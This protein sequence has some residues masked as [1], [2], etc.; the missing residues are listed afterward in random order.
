MSKIGRDIISYLENIA[1]YPL[2]KEGIIAGQC[3]A[4]TYF[5][6]LNIPIVTRIKDIDIFTAS[7]HNKNTEYNKENKSINYNISYIDKK[8]KFNQIKREDSNNTYGDEFSNI[9]NDSFNFKESLYTHIKQYKI[10]YV[11]ELENL[12]IVNIKESTKNNRNFVKTIVESFDINMVKIGVCLKTGY[13]Y[14]SEDFKTFLKKKQ[15]EIVDFKNPFK[16]LTRYLNK[17]NT[18]TGFYSD[19]NYVASLIYPLFIFKKA[20]LKSVS[21]DSFNNLTEKSKKEI[22]KYFKLSTK[23]HTIVKRLIIPLS[24]KYKNKITYKKISN[25]NYKL[26]KAMNENQ[27]IYLQ[28]P[29]FDYL[30]SYNPYS[31]KDIIE[32]IKKHYEID[33]VKDYI[34]NSQKKEI[35]Q[36]IKKIRIKYNPKWNKNKIVI[37]TVKEFETVYYEPKIRAFNKTVRDNLESLIKI[38]KMKEFLED[39]SLL[40]NREFLEIFFNNKKINSFIN[41]LYTKEKDTKYKSKIDVMNNLLLN[42]NNKL[43]QIFQLKKEYFLSFIRHNKL[44]EIINLMYIFKNTPFPLKE[45]GEKIIYLENFDIE[46][47]ALFE[48][49]ILPSSLFLEEMDK[50]K[51]E[52]LDINNKKMKNIEKLKQ[53]DFLK[54]DEKLLEFKNYKIIQIY[55]PYRLKEVGKEMNHCVGGYSSKL[56]NKKMLFF[57]VYNPNK[58]RRTLSVYLEKNI[59]ME[60]KNS[61]NIIIDKFYGIDLS[62]DQYKGKRNLYP[63]NNE[64]NEIIEFINILHNR[65][66]ENIYKKDSYLLEE[67]GIN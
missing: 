37:W 7:N 38:E 47:I 46:F 8:I 28:T 36:V 65:L 41:F 53:K 11:F 58:E 43:N 12:N 14:I 42:K 39:K 22:N 15:L 51:K 66:N 17:I 54:L 34:N 63:N 16:T 26:N 6:L 4:E 61:K 48:T 56:S 13:L 55:N 50:F 57:D 31:N 62:F 21:I 33:K 60:V 35:P 25:I 19:F 59:L 27:Y 18:S 64:T 9:L 10:K 23:K 40:K 20:E 30:S 49:K 3:V 44:F 2:P 67:L 32:D 45:I 52:I 29:Y 5:R 1:E 24:Q